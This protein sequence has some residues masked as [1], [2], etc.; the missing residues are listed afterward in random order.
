MAR[1]RH[2][3][4][5]EF[6][7]P[8]SIKTVR[9]GRVAWRVGGRELWVDPSSFLVLNDREPYSMEIDE[10]EPVETLVA[11][12]QRGFVE[13]VF[14]SLSQPEERRLD[15]PTTESVELLFLSRLRPRNEQLTAAMAG[16]DS[17]LRTPD[18]ELSSLTLDA[19]YLELAAMLV[20]ESEET[21]R[22]LRTV[23]AARTSTRK[24]LLRR[25]SRGRDYLH[26]VSDRGTTL[27]EVAR[28]AA[29][30]PFHFQRTFKRVFGTS[31]ARYARELRLQ[32]AAELLKAGA[33][34]TQV[35]LESGYAGTAAFS[36][37]FRRWCSLPPSRF[38]ADFARSRKRLP[39]DP[40]TKNV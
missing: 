37:S 34:V 19:C 26:S 18:R 21:R 12:F 1:S 22:R 40:L 8:L 25:V 33:H 38:A 14:R 35:A 36:T 11:F 16:I 20:Q 9:K 10:P 13:D 24:E 7:G 3:S 39:P 6:S 27:A 31:P 5:Q 30:S 32:H 29:M 17:Y 4:V 2:H 15:E 23:P 28:V